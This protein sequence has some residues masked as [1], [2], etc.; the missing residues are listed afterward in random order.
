MEQDKGRLEFEELALKKHDLCRIFACH[1]LKF[2]SQS[3]FLSLSMR[4]ASN[5]ATVPKVF[6]IRAFEI[7]R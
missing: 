7:L 1:S 2:C 4:L 6:S 3:V 5:C